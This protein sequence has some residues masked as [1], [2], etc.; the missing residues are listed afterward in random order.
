MFIHWGAYSVSG[1]GEWVANRECISF[2]D[3]CRQYASNF[4]AKAYDPDAWAALAKEAGMGYAVLTAR[5]HDGF[6]LWP[7]RT[8]EFHA[9]NI[10]PKRDLVGSYVEAFRRAGLRVGLY[11]SPADWFHPDYPGAY[12]RDWPQTKDWKSKEARLRMIA[13]Y[14]EQLR[15]LMT[16]YGPIDYLWYDGCLPEDLR[17]R[18]VNEEMLRLQPE[19]L[20]NE[21]NGEPFHVKICEQTIRAPES[22]VPWEAC[23]TLNENWG[24]HAGDQN[25]K[26]ERQVIRMLTETA[27]KAGNLLLNIGPRGDGSIP[28]E[29]SR[30]LRASGEWLRRND[31]SIRNTSRSPF[32]WFNWGRVTTQGNRVFLHIWNTTGSELCFAEIRNRVHSAA[33]LDDGTPV[34]FEQNEKRLLLKGLTSPLNDPIATVIVL[35]VEGEPEALTAQTTFW[36][37]E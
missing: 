26:S 8:S 2:D 25:W 15:E 24:Y 22:T 21:R 27:A 19:L 34:A 3:Y 23:M 13:Y 10:G 17:S 20:I 12:F 31:S 11:Y 33:Y 28:E 1:R 4:D 37:P 29:T 7:T 32:T 9:G 35:E 18:E 6:A 16:W 36:I 14:R 5:H 30:I